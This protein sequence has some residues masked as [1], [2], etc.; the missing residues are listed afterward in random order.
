MDLLVKSYIYLVIIGTLMPLL[1]AANEQFVEHLDWQTFETEHFRVHFTP[2]YKDWAISSAHEMEQARALIQQQQNRTLDE[3]VDAVVFDPLNLSNGYALPFTNKPFMGLFVTPPQSDSIISNSTSWQQLLVLHEYV[4]LV[5]LGQPQRNDWRFQL[6]RFWDLLDINFSIPRWASEG[7]ATLLESETSGRGRLYSNQVE[8]IL[9]QFAREGALPTYGQLSATNGRYLAGA[10]AYLMG[11]RYLKWLEEKYGEEKLDAVWTRIVA[12]KERSFDSAFSGVFRKSPAQLYQRFAAE[13]T[14]K[15]IQSENSSE[16]NKPKLWLNLKHSVTSPALS[17]DKSLLALVQVDD[18]QKVRLNLYEMKEN[19]KAKEKFTEANKELLKNDPEDIPDTP[20]EVFNRKVKHTLNQINY[21]GIRNPRWLDNQRILFGAST[22]DND[23]LLHQDLHIWNIKTNQ[24]STIT[25]SQNIRRFDL[26]P[27]SNEIYA[28]Q[29]RAGKSQIIR[30]DIDDVNNV[31]EITTATLETTYDFPRINPVNHQQ[32]AYVQSQLNQS[33]QLRV[34]QLD[35]GDEQI[36]P[37]PKGYQFLSYP[38]WSHNGQALYFVAGINNTLRLYRFNLTGETLEQITHGDHPIS[39]PISVSDDQLLALSV[40]SLGPDVVEVPLNNPLISQVSDTTK[41]AVLASA[42]NYPHQLPAAKVKLDESIGTLRPYGIG[43]Q[44]TS[45]NI[46]SAVNS[47]S[48]SQTELGIK[49]GDF[50]QR[51]DWQAHVSQSIGNSGLKGISSSVRWQ[52]W[53]IKFAAQLYNLELNTDEQK[54]PVIGPSQDLNGGF[55]RVNYPWQRNTLR[56]NLIGQFNQ[57]NSDI[58]DQDYFSLGWQQS[59]FY[60]KQSWG[61]YQSSDIRWLDGQSNV[62]GNIIGFENNWEGFN[63]DLRLGIEY[64]NFIFEGSA[65]RQRRFDTPLALISVGG[66][67]SN[68]FNPD[69]HLNRAFS[70]ELAFDNRFTNDYRYYQLSLRKDQSPVAL[71]YGRHEF[72]SQTDIDVYG[73]KGEFSLDSGALS[74]SDLYLNYGLLEV[75]PEFDSSEVEAW[76]GLR[77][78]F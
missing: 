22:R 62:N 58:I 32:L 57:N 33:W 73:F 56:I 43:R 30:L 65:T 12:K 36:I 60:N 61:I 44:E 53:P 9:A 20:P 18:K 37:A 6:E 8:A 52:G 15:A 5:H 77:Y 66:F 78:Q 10:M 49:G 19:D 11:V 54:D 69:A 64:R 68:I 75:K 67:A 45:F 28:E 27:D 17:P 34:K 29:T 51:F 55:I 35:T 16:L 31:K 7:Y 23:G 72:E 38:E 63:A 13:F 2:E 4:H 47:S 25:R 14:A 3:K 76:F 1:L 41:S 42:H 70:P 50:L 40:N 21:L 71:V 48:F 74:I 46:T 39:W 26:I 24:V 59:W